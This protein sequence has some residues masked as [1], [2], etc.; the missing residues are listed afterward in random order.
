MRP[1]AE[2]VVRHQ[3]EAMELGIFR[4]VRGSEDCG[5]GGGSKRMI[6][7]KNDKNDK[8]NLKGSSRGK[9]IFIYTVDPP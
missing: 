4:E 5:E 1:L 2:T 7:K 3:S 6:A 9:C 8:I